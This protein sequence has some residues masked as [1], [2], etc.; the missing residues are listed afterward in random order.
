MF[1]HDA[2]NGQMFDRRTRQTLIQ[3]QLHAVGP[4]FCRTVVKVR[5]RILQRLQRVSS[6]SSSG[7]SA[8]NSWRSGYVAKASSTRRTVS[9]S[10]RMHGWPFICGSLG[11]LLERW[12]GGVGRYVS[13]FASYETPPIPPQGVNRTGLRVSRGIFRTRGNTNLSLYALLLIVTAIG[14]GRLSASS[15]MPGTNCLIA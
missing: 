8:R 9:R 3:K 13:S 12:Q 10:P 5:R 14:Y 4:Q 11:A 1:R 2:L 7:Y 15:R 6:S